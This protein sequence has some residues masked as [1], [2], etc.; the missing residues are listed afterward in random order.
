MKAQMAE[1]LEIT[2]E[3]HCSNFT[4]Q[5]RF[6]ELMIDLS[7]EDFDKLDDKFGTIISLNQALTA[8]MINKS[9]LPKPESKP[10]P[11]HGCFVID[12]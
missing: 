2:Q 9:I 3:I 1:L 10:E 5:D 8:I 7:T 12:L 4:R 6:V 11:D